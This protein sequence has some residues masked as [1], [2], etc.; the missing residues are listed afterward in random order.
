MIILH[1]VAIC[2]SK[3]A[4]L[5]VASVKGM[6]LVVASVIPDGQGGRLVTVA[7]DNDKDQVFR[8]TVEAALGA[9]H[10]MIVQQVLGIFA[11]C[12]VGLPLDV[13]ETGAESVGSD[14]VGETHNKRRS[15]KR[16]RGQICAVMVFALY[17]F[18]GLTRPL[19][20]LHSDLSREA[21]ADLVGKIV[22]AETQ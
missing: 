15:G 22:L 2:R 1:T 14:S 6:A 5:V 3:P 18:V 21:R 13:I 17:F 12:L 10:C 9:Y 8:E 16:M 4:P 11:L 20:A 7:C 19:S